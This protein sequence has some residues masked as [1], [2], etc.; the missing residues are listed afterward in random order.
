MQLTGRSY[1]TAL[2][3]MLEVLLVHK[4]DFDSMN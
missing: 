3:Q 4:T 1:W 2:P